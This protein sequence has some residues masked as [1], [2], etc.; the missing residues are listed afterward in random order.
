MNTYSASTPF[1]YGDTKLYSTHLLFKEKRIELNEITFIY[2]YSSISSTVGIT[3]GRTI[4]C[5]IHYTTQT[6]SGIARIVNVGG[7]GAN[8][9]FKDKIEKG[10]Y[11]IQE[12][13]NLTFEYRLNRYKWD[14]QTKG[15]FINPAD[16]VTI[17]NN[18]DVK[19][20]DGKTAN[21]RI[22]AQ[23]GLIGQGETFT[24]LKRSGIDTSSIVIYPSKGV[25]LSVL[26]LNLYSKISINCEYNGDCLRTIVEKIALTGQFLE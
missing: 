22:A 12:I 4:F 7:T 14:L 2:I 1:I 23:N 15:F 20:K 16:N 5:E 17:Y 26:G 9:M 19:T 24:G 6:G 11:L 18:G 25:K 21:I 13:E 3:T 8:W 10:L